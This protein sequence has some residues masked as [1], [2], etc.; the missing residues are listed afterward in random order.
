MPKDIAVHYN[1]Y[2]IK[3]TPLKFNMA[4]TYMLNT[5]PQ[6]VIAWSLSI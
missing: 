4:Y 1:P 3:T 6:T 5:F 2:R